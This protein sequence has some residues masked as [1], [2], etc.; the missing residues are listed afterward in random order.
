MIIYSLKQLNDW[1]VLV[2]PV[3]IKP[4]TSYILGKHPN[5]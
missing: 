5:C 3:G 1:K 4:G 2:P